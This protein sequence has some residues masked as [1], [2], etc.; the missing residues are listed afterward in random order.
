MAHT[1]LYRKQHKEILD[2][3]AKITPLLDPK[4]LPGDVAL[5]HQLFGQLAAKLRVHLVTE[6]KGLFPQLLAHPIPEVRAK[7]Q[8]Y[9]DNM[10]TL[11]Q[12]FNEYSLRY[13]TLTAIQQAPAGFA[14]DSVRFFESLTKRLKEEDNDLYA[15]VDRSD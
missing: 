7:A 3:A 15:L 1:D 6:T 2:L 10:G 9:L 11:Q 5:A 14:R 12:A 8:Q 4:A 13:A